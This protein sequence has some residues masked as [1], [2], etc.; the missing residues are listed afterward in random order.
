MLVPVVKDQYG[1]ILD[2]HQR[3]RL[4]GEIGVK[5][6]VNIVE[7]AGEDEAREIARTL[8]EDRRAM[9]K[10]ERLPVVAGLRKDGQ[11]FPL[12]ISVAAVSLKGRWNARAARASLQLVQAL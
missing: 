11:R 8:N 3:V 6:P 7:V 9:P 10:D 4:A 1:S 2:G 5:Y 12:E